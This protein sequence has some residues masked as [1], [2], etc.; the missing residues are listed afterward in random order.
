MTG[1]RA[2]GGH[3]KLRSRSPIQS[4]A[5]GLSLGIL[6]GVVIGP[7]RQAVEIRDVQAGGQG[8]G[9][10]GSSTIVDSEEPN[11]QPTIGASEGSAGPSEVATVGPV[12]PGG[13]VAP[14]TGSGT[15]GP[16]SGGSGGG[17][18]TLTVQGVSDDTIRVGIGVPDLG[19]L[20]ALGPNYDFGDPEDHMNALL[21]DWRER[22]LV[23][24]H[25]RDLEFYPRTY[26]IVGTEQQLAA[27]Q[28]WVNDDKV[29]AVIA[30]QQFWAHGE[31]VVEAGV[32]LI[33][34]MMYYADT[35]RPDSG[36]LIFDLSPTTERFL[37]NWVHWMHDQGILQGK[38]IGVYRPI[39]RDA[40]PITDTMIPELNKLGYEV[41]VE[42]TTDN[43]A[44]GSPQDG[45]AVRRFASHDPPVDLALLMASA[46]NITNFMQQADA[47]IPRY[48]LS[49][50]VENHM[51]PAVTIGPLDPD[52]HPDGTSLA[53]SMRGDIWIQ[54]VDGIHARAVTRGPGYHFE[55]AWS[56][57]G[58]WL[59]FAVDN[60]G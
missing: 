11:A 20:A 33:T 7:S 49:T 58:A 47:Q 34:T 41:A 9:N 45:V 59:A 42:V 30:V 12:A 16:G 22:G 14:T 29:F 8:A 19:V 55:P 50:R 51:L 23:P 36:H 21:E 15:P 10:G 57:D 48:G 3:P 32:P 38:T 6:V 52:W 24:V 17:V 25:G 60:D 54:E 56:P 46:I 43:H 39:G 4:L 31:C 35:Y 40:I 44:T 5:V 28:G 2:A 26:D 53:Y 1:P 27:C 18:G 13:T 37:R